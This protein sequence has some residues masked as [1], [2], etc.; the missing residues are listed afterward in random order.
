MYPLYVRPSSIDFI[1]IGESFDTTG[2]PSE[3]SKELEDPMELEN[4]LMGMDRDKEF[5]P[6]RINIREFFRGVTFPGLPMSNLWTL[7]AY[8]D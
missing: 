2:S 5:S 7:D 4:P 1:P 6:F 8:M 3:D